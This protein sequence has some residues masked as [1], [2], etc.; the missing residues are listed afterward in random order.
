MGGG[1]WR[2]PYNK[3]GQIKLEKKTKQEYN[4]GIK[5]TMHNFLNLTLLGPGRLSQRWLLFFLLVFNRMLLIE[6]F[7]LSTVSLGMVFNFFTCI[8]MFTH[9][10]PLTMGKHIAVIVLFL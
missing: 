7:P 10:L 2:Y 9:Y 3:Q 8:G 1:R 5:N 4:R 6:L